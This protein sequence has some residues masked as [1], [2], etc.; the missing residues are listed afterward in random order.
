MNQTRIFTEPKAYSLL[1]LGFLCGSFLFSSFSPFFMSGKWTSLLNEENKP[2]KRLEQLIP[3]SVQS[4]IHEFKVI[5]IPKNSLSTQQR[6]LVSSLL[7]VLNKNEAKYYYIYDKSSSDWLET[8]DPAFYHYENLTEITNFTTLVEK[9]YNKTEGI[10]IFDDLPESANIATPLSGIYNSLLVHNSLYPSLLSISGFSNLPITINLTYEY[11]QA[12]FTNDS[13]PTDIYRWAFDRWFSQFNQTA[14]ALYNS[15]NP[16]HLRSFLCSNAIFTLWQPVMVDIEGVVRDDEKKT[17]A[18]TYIL[19]HTAQD[20]IVYGYMYPDGA[21]EGP[22]VKLL[23]SKGKYLVPSDWIKNLEFFQKL[24]LPE[25]FSFKQNRS[26]EMP[27]LQNKLYIAGIYSDGDNIQYVANFMFVKFWNSE[28]RKVNPVPIAYEL[29]PSLRWIAP[30]LMYY[31]YKTATINDYFTPG[32]G[33]KGYVKDN[34]MTAEYYSLY[35]QT[36]VELLEQCDMREMRTWSNQMEI[37]VEKSRSL[38]PNNSIHA[39]IDGYG[40]NYKGN[41]WLYK[42]TVITKMQGLGGSV[43]DLLEEIQKENSLIFVSPRFI[44]FHLF[45]WDTPYAEWQKLVN[46]TEELENVEVVRLDQ[47]IQLV[48]QYNQA[49]RTIISY[50]IFGIGT[51]IGVLIIVQTSKFH[52][53]KRHAI[54]IQ[55][56]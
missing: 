15:G 14:L 53:A 48:L 50:I 39:V 37:F 52:F 22:V 3:N 6:Y 34:H 56:D 47:L 43:D 2:S 24:P 26:I 32:V 4:G 55:N 20:I 27:K 46:A 23:S 18:L 1:L 28:A 5:E 33:G 10:V 17:E 40:G 8:M 45:C 42:D 19:D 25:S 38:V 29:T 51:A 13:H 12:Q 30:Y 7:G 41:P 36:T 54:K 31:F 9:L 49:E 11:Q 21:N 35:T 16:M 44:V